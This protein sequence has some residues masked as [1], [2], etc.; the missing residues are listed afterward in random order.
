MY[1]PLFAKLQ[2]YILK[3]L[4][5]EYT[6][7]WI[8]TIKTLETELRWKGFGNIGQQ[9]FDHVNGIFEFHVFSVSKQL[10]INLLSSIIDKYRPKG[11]MK[12]FELKNGNLKIILD[13]Q[14]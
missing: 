10:F 9:S 5:N 14:L 6:I 3:Y 4:A 13:K 8:E 2:K 11:K 12:L 7:T 1:Y